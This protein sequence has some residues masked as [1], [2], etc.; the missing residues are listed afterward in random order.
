MTALHTWCGLMLGWLLYAIFITGTASY[1]RPEIT[2]WMQPELR[3][4]RAE[5]AVLM[6]RAL[7]EIRRQAPDATTIY[8][9]FPN[10]RD[11]GLHLNW[12]TP[13]G[14]RVVRV[15]DAETARIEA[16]DSR[17]GEF[18]YRFHF[19]LQLPYPWGRYIASLAAAFMLVALFTGIV[20]HRQFFKDF[21]TFRPAKPGTRSWLDVHNLSGVIALPFYFMI[22]YSAQVI[23]V[24]LL[25]PWA[26]LATEPPVVEAAAQ[27]VTPPDSGAA[28][29]AAT[30]APGENTPAVDTGS[31][32]IPPLPVEAMMKAYHD[33]H[34]NRMLG[35]LYATG[36][37]TERGTVTIMPWADGKIPY[38]PRNALV[39]SAQD[40][41]LQGAPPGAPGLFTKIHDT[42]YG[43]HIAR[44]AGPFLRG[45]FFFLGLLGSV[46]VGTGLV[47]W[48]IKRRKR[49][50]SRRGAG[51]ADPGYWL[52][53]R[54]NVATLV[55]FPVALAAMLWANRLLPY[56]L[57][58]RGDREV[59]VVFT[60]W[61]LCFVHACLRPARRA[62]V[63]QLGCAAMLF[64]LL[65]F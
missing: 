38:E 3:P 27:P 4:H 8:V 60:V 55:G 1:Y 53:E 54:L 57:P 5:P 13:D 35:S 14:A 2:Q 24:D 65:P 61:A 21:F 17:G 64:T 10:D 36:L 48:T 42:F 22:A 56:D 51:K 52:V 26:R 7:N 16:R 19:Q 41:T 37:G 50:E 23:F 28:A 46:L 44:F 40:G 11:A 30:G 34:G 43:L 39:F 25:T 47:M 45:L 58:H 32:G 59:H 33:R 63:E 49:H 20:A 62:W 9:R 6:D 15:V 18:F 12:Q 29:A 31:P